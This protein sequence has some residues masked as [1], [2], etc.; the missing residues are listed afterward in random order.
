MDTAVRPLPIDLYRVRCAVAALVVLV[1]HKGRMDD[2][3]V[4]HEGARIEWLRRSEGLV[5]T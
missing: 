1:G 5:V 2:A 4:R 3:G